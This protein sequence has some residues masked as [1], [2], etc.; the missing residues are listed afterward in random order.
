M[1]SGAAQPQIGRGWSRCKTMFSPNI[2]GRDTFVSSAVPTEV[3]GGT[4]Y[5][6]VTLEVGANKTISPGTSPGS[7]ASA[8]QTW[9]DGG[10][11]NFQ[12]LDAT[13]SA[14]AGF[15][16]IEVT[17][18]L[19]L[20]GL[21]VG[22]FDI[23]LWSLSSIGPDMDGNATNFNNLTNYSWQILSTTTGITGFNSNQFDINTAAVNGTSGFS[24]PLGG[25]VFSIREDSDNLF[26]DFTAV[27]EPGT[28]ALVGLGLAVTLLRKRR[29]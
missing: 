17:G 26:L 15:D 12:V 13:G 23:N 10:S 28:W 7:L 3:R 20:S 4:N 27:P 14:G 5:S 29:R 8:G 21:G 22:Q 25:G 18:A 19:D 1:S 11:Y 16:T 6:G 24:N 2:V 9:T